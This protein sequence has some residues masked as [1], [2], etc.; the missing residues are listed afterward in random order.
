MGKDYKIGLICG[1]VAAVAMVIWVAARPSL[2]TGVRMLGPAPAPSQTVKP[3]PKA[4]EP[5]NHPDSGSSRNRG[6]PPAAAA[7]PAQPA[8][9]Q[10]SELPR[11][12]EQPP[13][14]PQRIH[15]VRSGETLSSI[16][17]LYYGT[18]DAW[19]RIL[20]ANADTIKNPDKVP[21]GTRLII[22]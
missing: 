13:A 14:A 3:T 11:V 20:K 18:S 4:P 2:N 10:H 16:S 22:P 12:V 8:E 5:L 15:T 19:Q 9:P 6:Q 7:P 1:L 17:Q 21:I